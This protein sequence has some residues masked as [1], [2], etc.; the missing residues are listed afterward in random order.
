MIE[1]KEPRRRGTSRRYASFDHYLKEMGVADEVRIA[2]EK[3][4]IAEQFEAARIRIGL[5]K[6]ELAKRVGTSRPQIDRVLDPESQ[7]VTIET[8]KKVAQAMGKRLHIEL[9]D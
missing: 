3:R 2:V 6:S 4:V 5:T 7:N 9:T 1:K 8:L